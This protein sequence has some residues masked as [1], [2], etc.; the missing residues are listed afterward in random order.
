MYVHLLCLN[1]SFSLFPEAKKFSPWISVSCRT[2]TDQQRE[3]TC[4]LPLIATTATARRINP[5]QWGSGPSRCPL[6]RTRPRS[7]NSSP[8]RT[9]SRPFRFKSRVS[10]RKPR[11]RN[12]PSAAEIF[13]VFSDA[14]YRKRELRVSNLYSCYGTKD[15]E[16]NRN[17]VSEKTLQNFNYRTTMG[18]KKMSCVIVSTEKLA[19]AVQ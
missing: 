16:N 5:C 12:P 3:W 8:A 1:W 2:S 19:S 7:T 6:C 10:P 14:E 17:F 9:S 13:A 4:W 11:G 18:T 15:D